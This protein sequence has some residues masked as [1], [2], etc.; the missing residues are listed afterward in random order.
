MSQNFFLKKGTNVKHFTVSWEIST[1]LIFDFCPFRPPPP[2]LRQWANLRPG[3]LNVLNFISSHT[4]AS[5]HIQDGTNRFA[6][7][8]GRK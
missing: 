4:T 6:N 8:E 5:G 2:P 7:I 3:Q 1:S